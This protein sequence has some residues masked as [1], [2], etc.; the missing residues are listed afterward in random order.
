MARGHARA[1][2]QNALSWIDRAHANRERSHHRAPSG[3]LVVA[4]VYTTDRRGERS[5]ARRALA[6]R[7][8][9][10]RAQRGA[11]RTAIESRARSPCPLSITTPPPSSWCWCSAT[12]YRH[13][14]LDERIRVARAAARRRC[15]GAGRMRRTSAVV[16]GSRR[17][18]APTSRSRAHAALTRRSRSARCARKRRPEDARGASSL[19][20]GGRATRRRRPQLELAKRQELD[21]RRVSLLEHERG[22]HQRAKADAEAKI[23]RMRADQRARV[24]ASVQ[25]SR[26]CMP[27][28][29]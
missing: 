14:E 5:R 29:R 18:S 11:R 12:R 24:I 22:E 10:A 2:S 17:T 25:T 13:R 8:S 7:R 20:R 4:T 9:G 3:D 28:R 6:L 15:I 21:R 16:F 26:S 19:A 1:P 27:T 23:D